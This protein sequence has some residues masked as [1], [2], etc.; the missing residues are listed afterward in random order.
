MFE[1]ANWWKTY[2]KHKIPSNMGNAYYYNV[3]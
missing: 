2:E 3:R 1:I